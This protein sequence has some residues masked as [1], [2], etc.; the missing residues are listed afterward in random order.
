MSSLEITLT[1]K[2]DGQPVNGFPVTRRIEADEVQHF[3]Y[4]QAAHG[5]I[6]TFGAV[7]ADQINTVQALVL[8]T[9]KA[10]TVRLDGQSDAGVPL[11][12]G[13]I[14]IVLDSTI[15]AGA[16]ASNAKV[17]NNSGATAL[18]EGLAAGT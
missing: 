12:A 14:L 7:P 6:T 10:I 9:T 18:I 5:D 16:G 8:R 13:G 3:S 2:R 11:N 17:N 1:V 4:E 15:D